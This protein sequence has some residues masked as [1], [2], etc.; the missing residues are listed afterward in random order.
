MRVAI[1]SLKF[2]ESSQTR[3]QLK[4]VHMLILGIVSW[5]I[6]ID[7]TRVVDDRLVFPN[8]DFFDY[9]P[10]VGDN[11]TAAYNIAIADNSTI[12]DDGTTVD[13]LHPVGSNVTTTELPT[14]DHRLVLGSVA[15]CP[16]GQKLHAGQ[17]RFGA[18]LTL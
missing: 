18:E 1:Q 9:N 2:S 15:K 11:R 8:D 13:V 16:P 10:T 4:A 17:C 14:V 7:Q 6:F 12:V 5:N 3:Q